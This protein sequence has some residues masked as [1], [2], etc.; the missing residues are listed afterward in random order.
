MRTFLGFLGRNSL[1]S[2]ATGF[3]LMLVFASIV[4]GFCAPALNKMSG[5]VVGVRLI[6]L[7][8]FLVVFILCYRVK[9]VPLQTTAIATFLGNI[10]GR[11][12]KFPVGYVWVPPGFSYVTVP[13]GEQM[14]QDPSEENQKK[15]EAGI[16]TISAEA[17]RSAAVANGQQG[18]MDK[19]NLVSVSFEVQYSFEIINPVAY[20]KAETSLNATGSSVATSLVGAIKSHV[21]EF[22]VQNELFALPALKGQMQTALAESGI[23]SEEWGIRQI[24]IIVRKVIFPADVQKALDDAAAE[25]GQLAAE[26]RDA[27]TLVEIAKVLKLQFP[28]L[29]DQQ[30]LEAAQIQQKRLTAQTIRG[31]GRAIVVENQPKGT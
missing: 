29:N 30:L 10:L 9:Q 21:R 8:I 26:T 18:P 23:E 28:G 16:I 15:K 6:K 27:G 22:A 1:L 31:G 20:F 7:A 2:L 14:L 13:A 17:L 24:R 4:A 25:I 5:D 12:R 19:A 3:A 11:G